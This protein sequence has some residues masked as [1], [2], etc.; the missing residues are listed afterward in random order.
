MLSGFSFGSFYPGHSFI[1]QMDPRMKLTFGFVFIIATLCAQQFYTLGALALFVLAFYLASGVPAK[2]CLQSVAPLMAIVLVASILNLFLVDTGETLVHLGFIRITTGG[3]YQ[4]LF[5]AARVTLIML[6]MSLVTLTTTTLNLS[7]AL[8]AMLMPFAR[9]GLPA[10]ELG[11]IMGIAL[12]FMPQFMDEFVCTYHA[13]MC[14]GAGLSSSPAKGLHMIVSMIVPLF[15][16]AFRHAETLS[17]AMDARCYHGA[18]GRTR[19]HPLRFG[20]RDGAA[21]GVAVL[22]IAAMATMNCLF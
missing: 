19:L 15:A 21:C 8:E 2:K 1:H 5:I 4:C 11:M 3:V 12:R 10:H 18:T 7:E 6:V 14:R 22:L 9:F 16:S 13:Q 20:W 17:D